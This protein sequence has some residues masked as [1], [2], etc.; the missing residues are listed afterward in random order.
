MKNNPNRWLVGLLLLLI[1]AK[2]VA[3]PLDS[4]GVLDNILD[5]FRDV[6]SHWSVA[7]TRHATWLFWGLALLSMAWTFGMMAL[8]NAGFTEALAELIRFLS[9]TGFF[10]WLLLNGPAISISITDS[11]RQIAAEA[12]GLGRSLSPSGIVDIGFD[13]V[14]K[15]VDQ[16]SMWSPVSSN[17]G[18]LLSAVILVCLALVG[19]NMLL[20][21]VSAWMLAYGGVFLLGFGGGR[22]TSDIAISFYKTV[23]GLGIQIFAMILLVGV[24]KSFVDQYYAS[25]ID[26]SITLKSLFVMLI[27]S[28]I[29]LSLVNKVPPMMASIVPG[30]GATAGIGNFGASSVIGAMATAA[31]AAA[32][33][34][35]GIAAGATSMAGGASALKAAFQQ[36]QQHMADGTGMFSGGGSSGSGE[37][38]ASSGGSK[39]SASGTGPTSG[40]SG[41]FRAAMG[42]A[43]SSVG[44]AMNTTSRFAADMSANLAKGVGTV[45]KDKASNMMEAARDRV[46]QTTGGKVAS[47]INRQALQEKQT[48]EPVSSPQGSDGSDESFA[49]DSLGSGKA[50]ATSAANDEVAAFV[51]KNQLQ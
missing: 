22:W 23:L 43:I 13:I 26:G 14:S 20:L 50:E 44:S 11:M 38:G 5:R 51:N 29:L 31:A 19:V 27:V 18:L 3:A 48:D 32:T 24:G 45:A 7:I 42:S 47:E 46:S 2:V 25:L 16:S 36:A 4:S 21:L 10:F 34:G 33:A 17:V 41:G 28:V 15:V 49:G 39:S 35:A 30:G 12:S 40:G 1:A 9:V 37:A 6:A 8:K